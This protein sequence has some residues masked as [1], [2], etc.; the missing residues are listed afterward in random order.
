MLSVMAEAVNLRCNGIQSAISLNITP[1]C[2]FKAF[3]MVGTL[4]ELCN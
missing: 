2:S 4:Q 3:S 1:S